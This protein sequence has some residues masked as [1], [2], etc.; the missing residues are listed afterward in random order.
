MLHA[1]RSLTKAPGFTLT[2]IL[3]LALGIGVNTSMFSVLNG[4]LLR[5][6][7]YP[8]PDRLFRLYHNA[9]HESFNSLGAGNFIDIAEASADLAEFAAFR[10]WAFTLTEPGQPADVPQA[11]RVTPNYFS[12][13]GR[14]PERGRG[15]SPE[16]GTPGRDSVIVLSHRYWQSRF[17]G[18][19]T[20]VGRTVY[21]DGAPVEIVGV[22]SA[23]DD[24]IRFLGSAGIYRPLVMTDADRTNRMDSAFGVIGRYRDGVSPEQ[25]AV[26]FETLTQ[27]LAADHPKENGTR[28]FVIQSLQASTLRGIGRTMTMLLIGLS[29]AVLLI[30]CANLANLLLARAIS[31]AREF[32]IRAALGGSRAQLVKPLALECLLLAALGGAAALL[33]SAWTSNWLERRYGS[34]EAPMDFSADGRVVAFT[35]AATLVTALLFGVA[36]AWWAARIDVNG[37][38]K[39]NSSHTTA[40]RSQNRY[41]QFLIVTQFALALVLLAGAGFFI[42][43]MR[44]LI[45]VHPGWNPA[46]VVSGVLNLASAKYNAA[47]P[48]IAFH[49]ELRER[50]LALPGVANASVSFE[51]PLFTPPQ[52]NYLVQGR[53]AP[54]PG[55]ELVAFTNAV[56]PSYFD[57]VGV[58][59]LRGRLIADTDGLTAPPVVVINESMARTLFPNGDAIGQRLGLAGQPETEWAEIIGVVADT[60]ALLIAPSPVR[61]QV[62][63]PYAQEAW[64]Y[65]TIAVRALDPAQ[66]STLLEPIRR[67][68]ASLDPD[69]PVMRLLPVTQR[70]ERNLSFWQTINQLLVIFAALGLLLSA[71]G[72]YGVIT[73]LALQRTNE[74]G[75]RIALGAQMHDITRLVLGGGLRLAFAG[76]AIGLLGAMWLGSF[77]DSKMPALG[78][79]STLPLAAASAVL[80][81]AAIAASYLP[82]RRAARVNP[83]TA[84]RAE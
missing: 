14:L 69:Q 42:R 16:D 59:L 77:L 20:A 70:I 37:A 74:F 64:Q 27:R 22:L 8:E 60:Q 48:I 65:V 44:Q 4:L 13:L 24:A 57:T 1:L 21:L 12:V 39:A 9:P 80:A 34:A 26:R 3:T 17:N 28:R 63:K 73:R 84:L 7:S 46:P 23:N 61:F 58:R 45:G 82:A 71:L 78:G 5:P 83:I 31:R 38:L 67:T 33:L 50:L 81:L 52:R 76:T 51:V 68:V 43:G 56:S 18:D 72:I 66:A 54:L 55:Q 36:P 47:E 75:I 53:E 79:S 29:G 35:I 11:V 62:Y 41:R 40:S 49:A 30:A 2:V 25:A 32:S 19:P 15:F 10:F 6:L